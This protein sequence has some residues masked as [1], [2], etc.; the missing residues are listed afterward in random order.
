[1]KMLVHGVRLLLDQGIVEIA[2]NGEIGIR[3]VGLRDFHADPADRLIV[4]TAMAGHQFSDC[5][6]TNSR[7]V[8][9]SKP[10]PSRGLTSAAPSSADLLFNFDGTVQLSSLHN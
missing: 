4:A 7:L 5:R 1:M 9:Y 6:P 10:P 3:A 2:V 8:R